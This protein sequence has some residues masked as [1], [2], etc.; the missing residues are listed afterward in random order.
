[1]ERFLILAALI[2]VA[3]S[4]STAGRYR[5]PVKEGSRLDQV[6]ERLQLAGIV[7]A[8]GVGLSLPTV[9]GFTGLPGLAYS[10][11]FLQVFAVA[12]FRIQL[13]PIRGFRPG[14]EGRHSVEESEQRRT[15]WPYQTAFALGYVLLLAYVASIFAIYF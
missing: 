7:A 3:I 1:M 5:Y 9:T 10:A 12:I 13:P 14:T 8:I 4:I 15:R 2:L 6:F 11:V